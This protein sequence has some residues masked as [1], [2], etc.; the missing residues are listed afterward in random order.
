MNP[1]K[2]SNK[3]KCM[4]ACWHWV[5][6]IISHIHTPFWERDRVHRSG[7]T[8]WHYVKLNGTDI[9]TQ[10]ANISFGQPSAPMR[11]LIGQLSANLL[12]TGR[13]RLRAPWTVIGSLVPEKSNKEDGQTDRQEEIQTLFT[14]R[15]KSSRTSKRCKIGALRS[16]FLGPI[17]SHDRG[18]QNLPMILMSQQSANT[19]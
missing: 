1:V 5:K 17:I 3:I 14:W 10:L 6:S 15:R 16:G 4:Y 19:D 8:L 2:A 18:N 13:K 11:P 9:T 12:E 7:C